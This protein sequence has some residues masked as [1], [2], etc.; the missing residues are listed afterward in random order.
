[1]AALLSVSA[2]NQYG[3]AGSAE[4]LDVQAGDWTPPAPV[5]LAATVESSSVGLSWGPSSSAD[6]TSYVVYRNG[7]PVISVGGGSTGALDA[8][9]ANGTYQ[10]QVRPIDAA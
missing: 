5:V 1:E 9:V 6:V 8:S 10:Y 3:V 7:Q 2:I 4:T